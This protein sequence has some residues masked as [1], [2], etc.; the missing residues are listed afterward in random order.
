[1]LL[2]NDEISGPV[3]QKRLFSVLLKKK[4]IPVPVDDERRHFP[5]S[6]KN[7]I[8]RLYF[9]WLVPLLNV[10]YRRTVQPDDLY[11]LNDDLTV[12]FYKTRF[13]AIFARR[14]AESR[15]KH[16]QK[17]AT[18][19]EADATYEVSKYDV[20]FSI[21]E[22][23]FWTLVNS[24]ILSSIAVIASSTTPLV[25]KELIKFVEKRSLGASENI[26]SGV[27]YAIGLF[28]M[29]NLNGLFINHGMYKAF[30]V[31]VQVKSVLT[32]LILEKSF[33]LSP[34]SQH[35][36][37]SG[38]INSMM[39][40]DLA[41]LELGMIYQ[42]VFI[43][44]PIPLAI[45]VAILV[46][47][48]GVSAV[49]GI[50]VFLAFI[51]GILVL[52]T[53]LFKLRKSVSDLTD[54]RVTLIREALNN[55]KM[56]KFYSWETPYWAN[57][58]AARA[59]EMKYIFRIQALRNIINAL[60]LSLIGLSSMVAFLSLYAIEGGT[61]TPADIFSSVSLFE[62]LGFLVFILPQCL[63]TTAD[64]LVACN[65]LGSF[66]DTSESAIDENYHQFEDA[67]SNTAIELKDA[68]FEW[69]VFQEEKTEEKG[70]GKG[71][72]KKKKKRTSTKVEEELKLVA[73]K[74]TFQ[75]K[76]V[77]L[78]VKKGEFIV[79]TGKIGSG[80]SSLLQ[81][82]AGFMMTKMGAVNINGSL[83]FSGAPWIQ[84]AT[85]RENIT[86]GLEYEPAF[87][88]RVVAACSLQDDF[89]SFTG[90]DLT[91]VGEK[92][93][94]LSGG[95]K[96]R[97]NLARSVY[98]NKDII[99]MDDCLSAVD[100]RVGKHI[101][102]EC[103]LGLLRDKTRVLA[104]HQLS[105]IASAN[106]VAYLKGDGTVDVGTFEE[107][108]KR[109][110]GFR[111]LLSSN[112]KNVAAEADEKESV[113]EDD[114]SIE[115]ITLDDASD[116][117][118]GD[119]TLK[120]RKVGTGTD[121][122]LVSSR[123]SDVDIMNGKLI[124]KEEQAVNSLRLE[125]YK[126]Y[127]RYGTGKFRAWGFF[128]IFIPL[129]MISTFA[130]I[131]T[132]TWLSFWVSHKF[133]NVSNGAYQGIYVALVMLWLVFLTVEFVTLI[134]MTTSASKN[135]NV[136]S[137]KR[138]LHAPMSF[139]DTNPMG[140]IMNRFTK[141]TDALDN[142]I[143]EQLRL[144]VYGLSR[145][146]GIII[147]NIIYLPWVALLIPIMLGLFI[148][149]A[150]YY[151]A[152][153]REIRRI[154]A[155][156]RSF[157][158]NTFNETLSGNA[159]IKAYK[160][161]ER[162][163]RKCEGYLDRMNEAGYT[164]WAL[165]RFLNIGLDLFANI[166]A[167]VISL[168]C[169]NRVFKISAATAGLL[170]SYSLQLGPELT[171]LIRSWTMLENDMNSAERLCQYALH[172]PQEADHLVGSTAVKAPW[173]AKGEIVFNNVSYSYRA[174]LP[175]VLKNVSFNVRPGERIGI[176]GRTGA[177]KSSIMNALYR[178]NELAEGKI[179]I[180]GVDISALG[181][182]TLRS[183]LSIIPQ[184]PALFTGS[185][186]KNLDPFNEH[187]DYVLW[188]ALRRAGLI[189]ETAL[190]D[191]KLQQKDLGDDLHKFHLEQDVE[192]EGRNFSLGERQ[193]IAFARAM[194]R[195]SK[196]LILDEATSSVDYETDNKVQMTIL[197]EFQNCTILCIAHRLKTII[198]YD[199]ILTMDNGKVAEL[200]TP[201]EL[202]AQK[203]STF[204]AM[205]LKSG[206][207][208]SDF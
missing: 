74:E 122:Q 71:K 16:R 88:H 118:R 159:T 9:L 136:V 51:G 28:M 86:F 96:A 13:Q 87:Y 103:L 65:R 73:K 163:S 33:R 176:C 63:S 58:L 42:T 56:I 69:E 59:A 104:T 22:T 204:R 162:F 183:N 112:V 189:E 182:S 5:S 194:V 84:N 4:Q 36:Y 160:A 152:S 64:V 61:R 128:V 126:T 155:V 140:R 199:R 32:S 198:L 20:L 203:D 193:L 108:E 17:C 35:K 11:K 157:V 197:R 177:G 40:T 62:L 81:A 120:Q 24:T 179:F 156:Q 167:L 132:N 27:G 44:L 113:D 6:M 138:I 100:A 170:V 3:Y 25:T 123:D 101:V 109:N 31:G 184:D 144:F 1:M 116:P 91:E 76:N 173:P 50:V 149:L 200:G 93:I 29:T 141:D 147:L 107:L 67:T 7:P 165:Q 80:K 121:Q 119:Q 148:T 192:E 21:Y 38:D 26:G 180:D 49:I 202:F 146:V 39:G 133:P 150:N 164:V 110:A 46:I 186:R 205:C 178:L 206:I 115:D 191:V 153:C 105:L 23:W 45:S 41:R 135:L 37:S 52:T 89:D 30:R 168:L 158:Y 79:I 10:G 171:Q 142:E 114:I 82:M 151:Q 83:L 97:I 187:Q 85:I 188:D 75:L 78:K 130:D 181:L 208:E 72:E 60:A 124:A 99:L 172:L 77:N 95:Q 129:M 195:D 102:S 15:Q 196:I 145:L 66:L 12:E 166:I 154:E 127:L 131:F 94:N 139:I 55:I 98:A 14:C 34:R 47:N 57:I 68:S 18:D 54:K 175:R 117:F 161:E 111:E 43:A 207:S 48:I 190:E 201:A 169:V 185:V 19:E 92:G 134:G 143:S 137:I 174:G 106:K 125:I 53:Y 90:G 70:D 8:S 2:D